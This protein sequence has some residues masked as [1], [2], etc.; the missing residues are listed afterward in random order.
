MKTRRYG[1]IEGP[2]SSLILTMHQKYDFDLQQY[3]H[4]PDF[5][6]RLYT[7]QIRTQSLIRNMIYS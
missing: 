1:D 5:T 7:L 2:F 3:S 4:I 6:I